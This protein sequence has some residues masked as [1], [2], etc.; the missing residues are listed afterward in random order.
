MTP[1]WSRLPWDSEFFG[2]EI[3]RVDLDG[4]SPT[5]VVAVEHEARAH[6][7]ACL[8]GT[9][10]PSDLTATVAAQALGWRFVDAA[11]MST[12]HPKQPPNP[13][14]PSITVR[15]GTTDDLPALE[16]MAD[17]LAP[18]SRFATDPRFGLEAARRLQLA[19][20]ER[21]ATCTTGDH[22]LLVAEHDGA[23]VAFI[24]RMLAPSAGI[25]GIGSSALGAG[26]ARLLV[27]ESRAWAG[28]QPLLGGPIAARNI[29]AHAFVNSCGYRA[30]WV[31][32]HYHRWLDEE[33][34]SAS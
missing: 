26:A 25:D 7:L 34:R 33:P 11:V 16:P 4:L 19:W 15:R 21:A 17:L 24:T 6:G 20:L 18:W 32:Y 30:S 28:D 10:D 1:P 14:P 29:V 22:D 8:Y 27:E 13:R 31:R 23:I 9:L 5:E 2:V 3:G 12:L